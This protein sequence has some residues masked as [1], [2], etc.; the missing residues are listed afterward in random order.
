MQWILHVDNGYL[1]F[2]THEINRIFI[3]ICIQFVKWNFFVFS[4]HT[5]FYKF[6]I[7][8]AID[9]IVFVVCYLNWKMF[10]MCTSTFL[11]RSLKPQ[12][13]NAFWIHFSA[14]RDD[15]NGRVVCIYTFYSTI[16]CIGRSIW[17]QTALM[18]AMTFSQFHMKRAENVQW[19]LTTKRLS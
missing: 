5:T 17:Q 14:A 3:F 16:S 4:C 8:H 10:E 2:C 1:H 15:I 6:K 11:T 9:R 13:C 19:C 18:H 7:L 12:R